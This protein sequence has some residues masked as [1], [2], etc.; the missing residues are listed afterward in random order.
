MKLDNRPKRLLIKG[1]NGDSVQAVQ[2]WY[3]STGQVDSVTTVDSGDIIVSF[4]TRSAAEQGLAKG[5]NIPLVGQVQVSWY[6]GQLP[7]AS[8]IDKA[9]SPTTIHSKNDKDAEEPMQLSNGDDRHPSP[10]P[11]EEEVVASGWGGDEDEDGMG[12]L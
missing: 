9:I 5:Q 1:V 10:H 6:T 11:Q 3:E 2:D 12:M 8:T 4:K 7:A